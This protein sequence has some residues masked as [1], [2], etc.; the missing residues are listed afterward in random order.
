MDTTTELTAAQQTALNTILNLRRLTA[1]TGT[2]TTR[3]Q[4]D[5]LQSL[6]STDLAAVAN[7]LSY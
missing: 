7:A 1:E 5:T 4:N 3:A 2:K 6:N